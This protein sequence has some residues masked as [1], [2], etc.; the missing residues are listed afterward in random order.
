MTAGSQPATQSVESV[1][2]RVT[3]FP[4]PL[5]A[6]HQRHEAWPR[7]GLFDDLLSG[8]LPGRFRLGKAEMKLRRPSTVVSCR[9]LGTAVETCGRADKEK[10]AKGDRGNQ[11]A[12]VHQLMSPSA[13]LLAYNFDGLRAGSV[14]FCWQVAVLGTVIRPG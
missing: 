12:A 13:R 14:V 9:I 7:A 8:G 5:L 4:L 6:V 2:R 10:Q 3:S 1:G 11:H